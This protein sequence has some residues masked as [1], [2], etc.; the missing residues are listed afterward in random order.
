MAAQIRDNDSG[1]DPGHDR[2]DSREFNKGSI[3]ARHEGWG[4]VLV[5]DDEET[6]R[7]TLG[8]MLE[9]L[10]YE[11]DFAVDGDEAV[12][13]IQSAIAQQR[14]YRAVLMDLTIRNGVGGRHA[15]ALL[16][17]FE[18]TMPAFV[19]SGFSEDPAITHPAEHGFTDSIVKPFRLSDLADL[20]VR[21]FP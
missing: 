1:E 21:H 7:E 4:C 2:P 8:D 6:I 18:K 12:A 13:K 20:F 14:P 16:R 9:I 15:I 19:T 17:Q 11:A 10:G 3:A 5:M